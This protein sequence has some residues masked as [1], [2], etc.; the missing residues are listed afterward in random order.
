MEQNLLVFFVLFL[1]TMSY[2]QTTRYVYETSVDPDSI[3]L[4]SMK[5]EKTFLDSK[6]S[7]SFSL[8]KIK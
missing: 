6:G 7:K 5:T 2:G 1:V 4:V 8:V 3:I